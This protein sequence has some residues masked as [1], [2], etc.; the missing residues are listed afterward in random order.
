MLSKFNDDTKLGG[1]VDSLE[2]GEDLQRNLNK[3]ED[4]AVLD[5]MKFNKAKCRIL[6]LGWGNPGRTDR[7]GN[8]MLESSNVERDLGVLVNGKLIMSQQCPG[9]QEGQPSPGGI[10]QSIAS[11]SRKGIVLLCSALMQPQLEYCVQFWCSYFANLLTITM[12][13][14]NID[15]GLIPKPYS[16]TKLPL[17]VE[18]ISQYETT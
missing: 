6:H 13:I 9:S 12:K 17:Q 5:H 1:V 7:R 16:K 3:S 14:T 15:K 18:H 2:G 8:E 10:R 11:Q 4:W